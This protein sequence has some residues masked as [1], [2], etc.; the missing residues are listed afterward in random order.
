MGVKLRIG[1]LKEIKYIVSVLEKCA[2]GNIWN[3]RQ[4]K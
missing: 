4:P 1:L 3:L 2:E